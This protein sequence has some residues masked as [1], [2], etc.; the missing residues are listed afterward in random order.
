[1]DE[2]NTTGTVRN[3]VDADAFGK[4]PLL[5]RPVNP[6]K[7]R[8]YVLLSNYALFFYL[9]KWKKNSSVS[10]LCQCTTFSILPI[11]R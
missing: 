1:M 7:Q 8:V 4:R 5:A 11:P 10:I 9:K 2:R 3:A 6:P